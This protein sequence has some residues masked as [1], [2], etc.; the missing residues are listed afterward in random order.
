MDT[1]SWQSGTNPLPMDRGRLHGCH[2]DGCYVQESVGI[3]YGSAF[4]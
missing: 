4:R 2:D 1:A 3:F